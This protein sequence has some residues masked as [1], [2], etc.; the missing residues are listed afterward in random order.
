MIL[1]LVEYVYE[2]TGRV[3]VAHTLEVVTVVC[4]EVG[5]SVFLCCCQSRSS[6]SLEAR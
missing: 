4:L 1:I 5:E 6:P 3:D 2:C